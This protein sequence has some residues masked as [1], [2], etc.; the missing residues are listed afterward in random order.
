[1]EV[2]IAVREPRVLKVVPCDV[3]ADYIG[4]RL[5]AGYRDCPRA[6]A[7]PNVEDLG[8]PAGGVDLVEVLVHEL[9]VPWVE[10]QR[11]DMVQRF[12][13]TSRQFL[14]LRRAA[15]CF[16]LTAGMASG[17]AGM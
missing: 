6:R 5:S 14:R 15:H 11:V 9:V 3:D 17:P 16:F 7:C 12:V 8:A 10:E 1:M 13:K 2:G 4:V